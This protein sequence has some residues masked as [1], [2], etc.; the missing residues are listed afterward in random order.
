MA[1]A[2][3]L[4]A[5]DIASGMESQRLRDRFVA[6]RAKLA[7]HGSSVTQEAVERMDAS[8]SVPL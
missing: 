2:N 3:A 1:A 5:L 6:L 7:G 4:A 8:L